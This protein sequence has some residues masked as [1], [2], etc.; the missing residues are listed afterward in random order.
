MKAIEISRVHQD[1]EKP[2][3]V[4]EGSEIAPWDKV[5]F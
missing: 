2:V 4:Q 5:D 1:P 3:E